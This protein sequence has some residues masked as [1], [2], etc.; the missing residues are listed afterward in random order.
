MKTITFRGKEYQVNP[1][2]TDL[3]VGCIAASWIRDDGYVTIDGFNQMSKQFTFIFPE[4]DFATYDAETRDG[5]LNLEVAEIIELLGI[6]KDIVS[7]DEQALQDVLKVTEE[8]QK[9]Q[10]QL[11]QLS[12]KYGK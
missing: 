1:N 12:S 9:L 11:N 10:D 2:T 3:H 8:M 6:L 7:T 5:T 4:C